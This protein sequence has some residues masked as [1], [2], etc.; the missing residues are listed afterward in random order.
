MTRLAEAEGDFGNDGVVRLAGGRAGQFRPAAAPPRAICRPAPRRRGAVRG[1]RPRDAR[2][3][4]GVDHGMAEIG[5]RVEGAAV[6]AALH[7]DAGAQP[8]AR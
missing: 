2:A 7:R 8:C 5:G 4:F 1:R 3:A 6:Q